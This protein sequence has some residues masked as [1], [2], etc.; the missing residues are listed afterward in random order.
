[1]FG[2]HVGV[3]EGSFSN[4]KLM[5]EKASLIIMIKR[6]GMVSFRSSKWRLS[7]GETEQWLVLFQVTSRLLP[8]P[9]S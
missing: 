6:L 7:Q 1:M 4:Y 8:Y 5:K 3:E 9:R 2:Q